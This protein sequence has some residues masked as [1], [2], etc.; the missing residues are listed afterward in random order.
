M[1]LSLFLRGLL[2][3]GRSHPELRNV[4][5]GAFRL[6]A[7]LDQLLDSG[8]DVLENLL[9]RALGLP[10]APGAVCQAVPLSCVQGWH[11]KVAQAAL[12]AAGERPVQR[13]RGQ[14]GQLGHQHCPTA[15]LPG[16]TAESPQDYGMLA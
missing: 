2:P 9:L 6:E 16:S 11:P 5:N 3:F 15:N 13:L 7:A 14:Q 1:I 4:G 10:R 8:W 12:G